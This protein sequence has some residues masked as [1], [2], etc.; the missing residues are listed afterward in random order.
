MFLFEKKKHIH[1][2]PYQ[3]EME[4][5]KKSCTKTQLFFLHPVEIPPKP[6]PQ[7]TQPEYRLKVHHPNV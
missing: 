7:T 4:I 2:H 3:K 1:S 6:S 5:S